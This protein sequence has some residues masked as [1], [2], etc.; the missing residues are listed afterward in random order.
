M[1]LDYVVKLIFPQRLNFKPGVGG[2]AL[3]CYMTGR[4]LFLKNLHNLFTKNLH[5]ITLFL[6]PVQELRLKN[7]NPENCTSHIGSYGSA[8][9]GF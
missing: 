4:C 1:T 5:F 7:D 8:P 6:Y 2:G 3:E 9:S